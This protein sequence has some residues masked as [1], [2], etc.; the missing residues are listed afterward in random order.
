MR[1]TMVVPSGAPPLDAP[2]AVDRA[3][4]RLWFA[5]I[6]M[7]V[8]VSIGLTW[9]GAWHARNKFETFNS[10]PHVFIYTSTIIT[11]LLVAGLTFSPHLRPWFGT[12]YRMRLFAFPMPGALV[13]TAGGLA[14]LGFAG[15]ALDNYWH[16]NFGLDETAWSM[17]HAMLGWSWF[18]AALGFIACRLALRPYRPLRWVTAVALGWLV[19]SF[20]MTPFLGPL[21]KAMTPEMLTAQ[22]RAI[23][24]LPGLIGNTSF[25]HV[26]RISVAANLTE[27]NPAFLLFSA[28]WMGTA[29]ALVRGIDRRA[30]ALLATVAI[31]SLFQL[32]GNHAAA[33]RLDTYLPISHDAR[34]WL[35]PPVLPAALALVVALR[36]GMR[37]QWAWAVAG[38]V[39]GVLTYLT[40]GTGHPLTLLL[41]P[42]AVPV[43]MAG[44]WIGGRIA[45][46]LANPVAADVRLIVPLLGVTAPLLMGLV[47]LYLRKTIA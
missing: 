47:D 15:L 16:T 10:P 4:R 44:A 36:A 42:L 41:L 13:I 32:L 28:L 40:W 37:E 39:F 26:R 29:L 8:T 27:T 25:A 35:P 24:T 22:N 33:V 30:K 2:T 3:G 20:S 5:L 18:V 23:A 9:D 31:F 1:E 17:P 14:M 7:L 34:N 45:R 46:M 19:L 11:I 6:F 12:A 43:T 21:H 38:G